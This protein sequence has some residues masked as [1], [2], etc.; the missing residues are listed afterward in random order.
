MSD[1]PTENFATNDD[2]FDQDMLDLEP[3]PTF[4]HWLNVNKPTLAT[5]HIQ[6]LYMGSITKKVL[7]SGVYL[8]NHPIKR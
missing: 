3:H 5:S 8:S 7:E 2:D 4:K 1:L 6:L